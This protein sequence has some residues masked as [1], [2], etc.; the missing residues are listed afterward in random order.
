MTYGYPNPVMFEMP[1]MTMSGMSRA[2][3]FKVTTTLA[4]LSH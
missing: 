3:S 1:T 4:T 2:Q